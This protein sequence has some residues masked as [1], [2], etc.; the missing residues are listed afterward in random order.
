M[1]FMEMMSPIFH[2]LRL[3]TLN[4]AIKSNNSLIIVFGD[5]VDGGVNFS[6]GKVFPFSH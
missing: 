5:L 6:P 2:V 4:F 3:H 1:L